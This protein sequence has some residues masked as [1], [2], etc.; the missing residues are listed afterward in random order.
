M[1]NVL[2]YVDVPYVECWLC[3]AERPRLGTLRLQSCWTFDAE[4]EADVRPLARAMSWL[5]LP[6][7]DSLRYMDLLGVNEGGGI[8]AF[9]FASVCRA[10]AMRLLVESLNE[11][12]PLKD[13]APLK[14]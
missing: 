6:S 11:D 7:K 1:R 4:A 2:P 12:R 13:T 10:L 14:D 8:S 5:A 3:D 9:E